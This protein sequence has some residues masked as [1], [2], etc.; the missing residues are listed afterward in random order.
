MI[1]LE[2]SRLKLRQFVRDDLD[3]LARISAD[4][5]TRGFL[6]DGPTDHETTTHN[7]RRWIEEYERGLG[8]LAMIHKPDGELIGHCGLAERDGRIILAY[9]LC[10]DHWCKGLAPEALGAVLRYGFEGLGLEEIWTGTRP[11][12]S[13]WRS[14]M[15][16]LGMTLREIER[17]GDGVEVLYALSSE[18]FSGRPAIK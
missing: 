17:T 10:K 2:T 4:P 6:W 11:E 9:A 12:N 7:L 15:E 5:E 3:E 1:E 8:H 13:A 16:K 14:M 18:E